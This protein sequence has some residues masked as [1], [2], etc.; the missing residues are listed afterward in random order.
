MITSIK[1]W[2]VSCFRSRLF[3][4]TIGITL[5]VIL[6]I[7]VAFRVSPWLGALVIRAVFSSDDGK[8]LQALEKHTPA[9][10]IAAVTNQSYREGDA[11]AVLDVYYPEGTNTALPTIIWT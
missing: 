11:D 7:L 1:K 3:W 6:I 10:L 5:G 8:V 2:I 9:R 4:W